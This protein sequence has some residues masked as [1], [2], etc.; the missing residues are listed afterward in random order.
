MPSD[1]KSKSNDYVTLGMHFDSLDFHVPVV[2]LRVGVL[3]KCV[4]RLR[5][6]CGVQMMSV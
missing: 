6:S 1:A 3:V 5:H 4:P 2:L